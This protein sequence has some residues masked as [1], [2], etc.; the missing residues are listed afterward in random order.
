MNKLVALTVGV[1]AWAAVAVVASLLV[2]NMGG[3]NQILMFLPI[4]AV[5]VGAWAVGEIVTERVF[6]R[7]EEEEA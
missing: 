1:G 4:L 5:V 2:F 7:R 6:S 3:K